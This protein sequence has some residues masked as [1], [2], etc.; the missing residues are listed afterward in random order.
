V[1][2]TRIRPRIGVLA[3]PWI[4]IPP[5]SY[6]GI[7]QVV[8]LL[9]ERLV[10]RDYDVKLVAA[11]GSRLPGGTLVSPLA[12]VPDTIGLTG[13]EL[14]HAL[15]GVEELRDV[16]L[17]LDH[18]G[19][20]G[21]LLLGRDGG[22]PV[23]HVAHGPLEGMALETYRALVRHSPD[24]RMVALSEAQRALAPDLPFAGVCSNGIDLD[25][26]PFGDGSG[27]HLAFLGRMAPEKGAREAI[28]V[29][30]RC[31][32]VL[33]M[34]AKCREPDEIAYFESAVAPHIGPGVVWL[35]EIGPEEKYALLGGAAALVF[36]I[37]WPE[38]FGMV[39]IEAMACGTPVLATPCGSVPEVVAE[40]VSGVIRPDPPALAR[41]LGEAL[42]IPRRSCREHVARA[43]SADVMADGY[44]RV[45][46]PLLRGARA[47]RPGPR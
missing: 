35:G 37:S 36:P 27:G 13:A 3:P 22:P 18:S 39:M 1:I 31:G 47:S 41:A 2:S 24:V 25:G 23:I 15:A 32:R 17:I 16:D 26:V 38:P 20:L 45:M 8:G 10:A 42:S 34:A 40:G 28:E 30:R 44:E 12:Q 7:E 14:Y 33:V 5:V 4:P 11:P 21:A 29:A 43:F 46:A 9:C 19:A 6:G